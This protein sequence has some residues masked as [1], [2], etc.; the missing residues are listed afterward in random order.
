[1]SLSTTSYYVGQS[2]RINVACFGADHEDIEHRTEPGAIGRIEEVDI[3]PMPQ[4]RTITISIP[5][6]ADAMIVNVFDESDGDPARYFS[7]V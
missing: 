6:S 5:V 1:M 4:G 2:V 3:F 7:P